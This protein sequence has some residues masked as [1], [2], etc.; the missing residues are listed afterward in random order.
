MAQSGKTW[1]IGLSSDIFIHLLIHL[2][3]RLM[4]QN[5]MNHK[6]M[7]LLLMDITKF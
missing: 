7:V 2:R 1:Q 5:T 4:I 6:N 3:N